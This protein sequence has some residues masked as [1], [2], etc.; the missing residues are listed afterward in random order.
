MCNLNKF[1]TEASTQ[2]PNPCPYPLPQ[3][4]TDPC[5]HSDTLDIWQ[6]QRTAICAV[7]C[8]RS[9]SNLHKFSS[10]PMCYQC[11]RASLVFA[12]SDLWAYRQH[13][14][15]KQYYAHIFLISL[16]FVLILSYIFGIF[17]MFAVCW[18][19]S[20]FSVY[21]SSVCPRSFIFLIFFLFFFLLTKKL[22][23][24]SKSRM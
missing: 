20:L 10:Q 3:I 21:S 13:Y 9:P 1:F 22:F 14:E 2:L 24:L 19:F 5:K 12:T 18:S 15:S 7:V 11:Y 17:R 6:Y 4:K 23:T 8:I 16:F